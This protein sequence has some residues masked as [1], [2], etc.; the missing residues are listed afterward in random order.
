MMKN[1]DIL[2]LKRLRSVALLAGGLFFLTVCNSFGQVVEPAPKDKGAGEI[3]GVE[4]EIIQKREVTLPPANRNF[5]KIPPRPVEQITP[6]MQYDFRSF[7]FS[8]PQINAPMRPLKVKAT[9]DK[10]IYGGFLRAG[11]GN[12]GSPLLEGYTTSRKDRE[13]LIGAHV[14]HFSS[15]K[16]PVDGKNSGNGN[17][18][19]SVF[20]KSF[21]EGLALSGNIDVEN[22]STHFYGYPDGFETEPSDI[23]QAYNHFQLSGDLSNTGNEDFSWKL[24][25]LFSYMA[26]RYDA[27]EAEGDLTF[28][29]AYKVA[30]DSRI[31]IDLSYFA[32]SRR[33]ALVEG[34]LRNLLTVTPTYT[35]FPVDDFKVR[36]GLSVAYENDTLDAKNLHIYPVA[37][38]SYPVN[39]SI[40]IY[41]SFSGSME[42]V[43]LQTLSRKNIWIGPNVPVNHTN[44]YFELNI[45]MNARVGN[46][47]G[48]HAGVSIAHLQDMH[49]FVNSATDL[50]K[51][52]VVYEDGFLRRSNLFGSLSFTQSEKAKLMIR[53]DVFAYGTDTLE[54]AWHLP[55]YKLNANASFNILRKILLNFDVI[56][57]GGMKA[58]RPSDQQVVTLDGALD[59]NARME[60][61]F[62]DNFSLFLQANNITGNNYPLFLNYPV[63][64][65]QFLGGITVSF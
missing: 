5:E 56:G 62:S 43:S 17:T 37:E 28:N 39:P 34:R 63:R 27:R 59:L 52:D 51:F 41:A 21:K 22:R 18:T 42:K 54:E 45:G 55:R 24:G 38:A 26:D 31:N 44:K 60:Y 19:V 2:T 25:G 32:I 53:G 14:Y 10:T 36:L 8:A 29:S 47:V 35:F 58:Y 7:S 4:I 46:K 65:F 6:P 33:D 57:M 12:Y 30:D 49:F 9:S 23:R 13:K 48:A 1:Q 64:G 16:G 50:S 40:D 61:L 11:Y 3:E 20:G 15:A